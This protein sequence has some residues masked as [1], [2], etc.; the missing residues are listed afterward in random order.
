MEKGLG[1]SMAKDKNAWMSGYTN[2]SKKQFMNWM[3]T[4]KGQFNPML[5]T[6]TNQ[7]AL[8]KPE[9]SEVV[10]Q[11]Q[12]ILGRIPGADQVTAAYKGK[13]TEF[14]NALSGM[15]FA[16]GGQGVSDIVKSAAGAIG[17][18]TGTAADT[19]LAAGTVSGMGGQGGDVYSKALL[20]GATARFAGLEA[21]TLKANEANRQAMMLGIGEATDAA[22]MKRMELGQMLAETKGKKIG[23]N[24][25]PFDV[26]SMI[27]QYQAAQK[28]LKGSGG[29]SKA[30]TTTPTTPTGTGNAGDANAGDANAGA[31][32]AQK[33]GYLNNL[34]GAGIT[35][36]NRGSQGRPSPR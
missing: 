11:Y 17:A 31:A 22:R 28:A 1:G 2:P 25:N 14:A 13:G 19:A 35:F 26:A 10:K 33:L 24:Q 6:L 12:S 20:G 15:N 7:M 32:N 29:K 4:Q 36:G 23:F 3:K 8:L 30:S 18:D 21:D 5:S 27:M 16:R 9:N 34:M